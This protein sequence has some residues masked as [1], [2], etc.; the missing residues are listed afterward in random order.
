MHGTIGS[1]LDHLCLVTNMHIFS[2]AMK[3][4]FLVATC[5]YIQSQRP[6]LVYMAELNTGQMCQ[7]LPTHQLHEKT[8]I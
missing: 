5:I 3:L 2:I 1:E 8:Q 4:V 6:L 7:L